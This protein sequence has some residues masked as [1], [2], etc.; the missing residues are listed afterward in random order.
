MAS[1]LIVDDDD[2]VAG[3]VVSYR[4]RAGFRTEHL[5]DDRAALDLVTAD[6]RTCSCSS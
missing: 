1:V 2:T 5:A 4:E 3:L 6:T